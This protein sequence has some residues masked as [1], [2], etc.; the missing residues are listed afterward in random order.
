MIEAMKYSLRSQ[1]R[2][3]LFKSKILSAFPQL[4]T[5]FTRLKHFVYVIS[6][7]G[8]GPGPLDA[9]TRRPGILSAASTIPVCNYSLPRES[10][11]QHIWDTFY[12]FPDNGITFQIVN[13]SI[14]IFMKMNKACNINSGMRYA[15]LCL[16]R[17]RIV[18]WFHNSFLLQNPF[19]TPDAFTL[20]S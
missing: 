16:L 19:L 10:P 4:F 13:V 8:N 3:S 11:F 17:K 7:C 14:V 18:S 9:A 1:T 2:Q 15:F 5:V 6:S 20:E 12:T